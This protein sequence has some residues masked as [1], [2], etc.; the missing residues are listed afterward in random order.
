MINETYPFTSGILDLSHMLLNSLHFAL[1]W[2]TPINNNCRAYGVYKCSIYVTKWKIHH[3]LR[4]YPIQLGFVPCTP[5][6][7]CC[8]FIESFITLLTRNEMLYSSANLSYIEKKNVRIRVLNLDPPRSTLDGCASHLIHI[9]DESR[10][11][12]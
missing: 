11:D 2:Y 4:R 8:V 7:P 10:S 3:F 9:T 12:H 5:V 6:V 1:V